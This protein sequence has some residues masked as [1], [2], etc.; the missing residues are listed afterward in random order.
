MSKTL[1][2]F[3]LIAVTNFLPFEA[4]C[5]ME[6]EVYFVNPQV[7]HLWFSFGQEESSCI[8][9]ICHSVMTGLCVTLPVALVTDEA[10]VL[11]NQAACL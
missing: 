4:W 2:F 7:G 10:S 5:N 11:Y 6:A 1:V 9:A 3:Q 8:E